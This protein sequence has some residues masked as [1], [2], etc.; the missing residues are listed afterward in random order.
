MPTLNIQLDSVV[1][2]VVL[3]LICLIMPMPIISKLHLSSHR[4]ALL[5]TT[6]VLGYSVIF[7]SVG[8]L[9]TVAKLRLSWRRI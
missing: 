9:V 2:S 1:P 8:R 3:D 7:L 6:L 4:K 5:L